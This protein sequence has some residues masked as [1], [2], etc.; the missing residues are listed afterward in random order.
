MNDWIQDNSFVVI[1]GLAVAAG[2]FLVAAL[3][4]AV[5]WRD[6]SRRQRPRHS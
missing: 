4:L 3:V 1:V 2:V 5:L 6:R